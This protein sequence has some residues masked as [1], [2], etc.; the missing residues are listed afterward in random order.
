MSAAQ[1]LVWRST[2]ANRRR[3]SLSSPWGDR[4]RKKKKSR[5]CLRSGHAY[6]LQLLHPVRPV[7]PVHPGRHE[8]KIMHLCVKR[9]TC[10][11]DRHP[12]DHRLA[13]C[14]QGPSAPGDFLCNLSLTTSA[15]VTP[16]QRATRRPWLSDAT[17]P[18]HTAGHATG[19]ITCISYHDEHNHRGIW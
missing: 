11:A 3:A 14:P 2:A 16:P 19:A 15:H 12:P 5:H 13:R 4:E 1:L 7:H 10:V 17:K 8:I 6:Q 9:A 18:I